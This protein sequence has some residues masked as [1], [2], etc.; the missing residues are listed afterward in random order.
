[1]CRRLLALS[2]ALVTAAACATPEP[3]PGAG[4]ETG[5]RVTPS[6]DAT[7]SPATVAPNP[8]AFADSKP[9]ELLTADDAASLGL[10]SPHP[11][12]RAPRPPSCGWVGTD[13][14]VIVK[15]DQAR[16]LAEVEA[17]RPGRRITIA[18]R[19]VLMEGDAQVAGKCLL[20]L[21]VGGTASV[22]IFVSR[23]DGHSVA[24]LNAA[25][26]AA[27]LHPRLPSA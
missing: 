16:S 5:P 8:R 4:D 15:I 3:P 12:D 23:H 14:A 17:S 20:T 21:D 13:F 27:V 1:M 11:Q 2:L 26:V 6:L 19:A 10:G 24:C 25:K 18:G 22:D 7:P 9:C